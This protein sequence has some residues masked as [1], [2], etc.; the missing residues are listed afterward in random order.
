EDIAVLCRTRDQVER[1]RKALS[2]RGVPSVAARSGGI[3]AAPVA[4][5][6]RRFLLALERPDIISLVRLAAT[7]VLVGRSLSEVATLSDAEALDL[8]QRLRRWQGLLAAGGIPPVLAELDRETGLAAR[9]LAG[10]DG[11]R[12]MTDLTHIAEELHAT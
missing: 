1:V 5:D 4:E 9:V 6:W 12:R 7:T 2:R 10:P 3:F 11:E 8:Q